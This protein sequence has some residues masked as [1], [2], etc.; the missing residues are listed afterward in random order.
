MKTVKLSAVLILTLLLSGCG[1]I[2]TTMNH[3]NT[4]LTNV[5]LSQNNFVVLGQVEGVAS[6]TYVFGFGGLSKQLYAQAK[7]EM[8]KKANLKGRSRAIV[9]VTYE[10]HVAI[11]LILE[12][13]TVTATGT[14]IE[15]TD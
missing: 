14:V 12:V 13:Y 15:F 6:S 5:E 11:Y 7:N 2:M 3:D 1:F 9:N 10:K 4:M 8:I